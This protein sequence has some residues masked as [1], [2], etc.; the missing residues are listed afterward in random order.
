VSYIL[1]AGEYKKGG[2]EASMSF[3]GESLGKTL[4]DGIN[5][6]ARNLK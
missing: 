3:Y 6:G 2:Y 1:P 5:R 4:M